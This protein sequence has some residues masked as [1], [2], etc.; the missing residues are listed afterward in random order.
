MTPVSLLIWIWHGGEWVCSAWP[1]HCC[2]RE[3]PP[4]DRLHSALQS[5]VRFSFSVSLWV[6]GIR[7]KNFPESA[8]Q[9]TDYEYQVLRKAELCQVLPSLIKAKI[10]SSSQSLHYNQYE[11]RCKA[12]V[13]SAWDNCTSRLYP[14][15]AAW[16]QGTGLWA[17]LSQFQGGCRAGWRW[18]TGLQSGDLSVYSSAPL[19]RY[20]A[21]EIQ[22]SSSVFLFSKMVRLT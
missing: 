4:S 12:K 10:T 17:F 9:P 8:D 6:H 5:G 16:E 20:P 7:T 18:S 14:L 13:C 3:L 21:W 22:T 11:G 19:T 15:C 2:D 1:R